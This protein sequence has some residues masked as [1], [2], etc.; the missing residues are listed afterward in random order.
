M[1]Y[2]TTN[3]VIHNQLHTYI[4]LGRPDPLFFTKNWLRQTIYHP[5]SSRYLIYSTINIIN[6]DKAIIYVYNAIG[7]MITAIGHMITAIAHMRS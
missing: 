1:K 2:L 5:N 3:D 4:I 6:Y 7:H